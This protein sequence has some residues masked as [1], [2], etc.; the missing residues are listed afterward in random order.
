ML[1]VLPLSLGIV[2]WFHSLLHLYW[3]KAHPYPHIHPKKQKTLRTLNMSLQ[4]STF[5]L[6]SR[7]AA[8]RSR[9]VLSSTARVASL[10]TSSRRCLNT[11]AN[12]IDINNRTPDGSVLAGFSSLEM[13][14]SP[15]TMVGQ[16]AVAKK[17]KVWESA[18]EAVKDLKSGSMV[19]SA[20]MSH[21][22]HFF[23]KK[24]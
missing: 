17:G 8:A 12:G 22:Q 3:R 5:L 19:L 20:G 15:A 24:T 4:A 18:D 7:V 16:P 10:Q 2:Y 6:R 14:P 21:F 13:Y 9:N 11:N 23:Y 1:R